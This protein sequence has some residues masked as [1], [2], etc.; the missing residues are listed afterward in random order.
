MSRRVEI[1]FILFQKDEL[2]KLQNMGRGLA[3]GREVHQGASRWGWGG[4]ENTD[5]YP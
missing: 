3:G 1:T 5:S 4:A 2:S